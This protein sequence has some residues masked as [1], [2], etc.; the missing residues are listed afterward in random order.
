MNEPQIVDQH[1]RLLN[2]DA[3]NEGAKKSAS[4]EEIFKIDALRQSCGA[5][6]G[7]IT[8]RRVNPFKTAANGVGHG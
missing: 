6:P 7:T 3:S 2:G 1:G 5:D 4:L 8:F